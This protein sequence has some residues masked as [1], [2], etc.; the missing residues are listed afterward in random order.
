MA[1]KKGKKQEVSLCPRSSVLLERVHLLLLPSPGHQPPVS[2][3]R[4]P[5][6]LL[7]TLQGTFRPQAGTGS[8]PARSVASSLSTELLLDLW[9]LQYR[10][11]SGRGIQLYLCNKISYVTAID[12][13]SAGQ[14]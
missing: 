8:C 5:T 6:L 13:T 4:Q 1:G 9:A 10:E 2:S 11:G 12:S 3:A 7:V 14:P